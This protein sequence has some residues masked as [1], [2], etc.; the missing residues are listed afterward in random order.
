MLIFVVLEVRAVCTQEEV[1]SPGLLQ[2][3]LFSSM[4][5]LH[6]SLF[7]KERE[8]QTLGCHT[9]TVRKIHC[10]LKP[11]QACAWWFWQ[12]FSRATS[13][14]PK[15]VS[16]P[17]LSS[18]SSPFCPSSRLFYLPLSSPQSLL[19]C[20]VCHPCFTQSWFAFPSVVSVSKG[21]PDRRKDD[22]TDRQRSGCPP[23][24]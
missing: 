12:A 11:C 21:Q 19:P 24:S 16:S 17:L 4:N 5:P 13:R 14:L 20:L 3:T 8:T 15:R 7:R 6:P 1:R 18:L 2:M 10:L 23:T 22:D 9:R